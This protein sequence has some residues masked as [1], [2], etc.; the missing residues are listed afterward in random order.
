MKINNN[1]IFFFI[2]FLIIIKYFYIKLDKSLINNYL[3]LGIVIYI[4]TFYITKNYNFSLLIFL[5][6]IFI[7]TIYRYNFDYAITLNN[8]II[9]FSSLLLWYILII[10]YKKINLNNIKL[11]NFIL[12][13]YIFL[14]ITEYILHKYIMHNNGKNF[15]DKFIK[16]IPYI[17]EYWF[18][19]GKD[20]LNHHLKVKK[21]MKIYN[22][23][24][25][26]ELYFN[27]ILI[28]KLILIVFMLILL[29][30][31]ITKYSIS[32]QNSF[33]LSIIIATIFGYTWNKVHP[34]MHYIN[35]K[36]SIKK[37]PY[38]EGL[39]D[40]SFLTKLLYNNHMRH[41]LIKGKKKGNYCI[42]LL[43]ADEWFLQNNK[44]ID[45]T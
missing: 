15:Y 11:I 17:N 12:L 6:T 16:Y 4:F 30:K 8:N 27:W 39:F 9:F 41:H 25:D 31:N 29:T 21:N 42:I 5:L 26:D 18:E 43:G 32:I 13:L 1:I 44:I 22:K 33:L 2:I 10:N 23:I 20:H 35:N 24:Y 34:Q 7:R 3:E 14:S 38:D 28:F 45:N 36:Y 40:L 19:I 37:G